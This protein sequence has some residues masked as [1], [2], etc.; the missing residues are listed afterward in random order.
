MWE[1]LGMLLKYRIYFF[2]F[3]LSLYPSIRLFNR[4]RDAKGKQKK[5]YQMKLEIVIF[6]SSIIY[7]GICAL[8]IHIFGIDAFREVVW[9]S[10]LAKVIFHPVVM[11]VR[12]VSSKTIYREPIVAY[13]NDRKEMGLL[14]IDIMVM[15]LPGIILYFVMLPFVLGAVITGL[16][17]GI[18]LYR[19]YRDSLVV[20]DKSVKLSIKQTM[21]QLWKD[22]GVFTWSTILWLVLYFGLGDVSK[23][24]FLLPIIAFT[25]IAV[26]MDVNTRKHQIL[27]ARQVNEHEKETVD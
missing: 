6:V 23:V 8:C 4:W 16:L 15:V 11:L 27:R 1:F 13:V 26:W 25:P 21:N 17:C 10:V 2:L 22:H 9:M 3:E 7:I 24:T 5:E 20:R 12:W 18:I 19:A 14:G